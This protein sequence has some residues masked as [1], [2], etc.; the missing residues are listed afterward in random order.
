[1]NNAVKQYKAHMH[2][3]LYS[4]FQ[5][6]CGSLATQTQMSKS[7]TSYIIPTHIHNA[8]STYFQYVQF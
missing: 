2:I 6:D 8:N 3:C 5:K 4:S 7:G 1:M